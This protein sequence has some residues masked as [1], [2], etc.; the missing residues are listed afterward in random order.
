M[1]AKVIEII[2]LVLNNNQ[3]NI[4][5][6]INRSM[7]LTDD[8]GFDSLMLAELTVHIE[9]EFD[10]DIFETGIV[11]TIEEILKK[12]SKWGRIIFLVDK[13]IEYSY[14]DLLIRLNHNSTYYPGSVFPLLF[15]FLSINL[16]KTWVDYK[17]KSF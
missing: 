12:L 2:L 6:K 11:N 9:E 3:M 17:Y 4:S 1:E 15:D 13:N 8:L 14:Q 16:I 10:V 7:S 5:K